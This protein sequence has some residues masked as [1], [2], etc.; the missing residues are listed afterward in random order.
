[1]Y[2][3]K[4]ILKL[5]HLHLKKIPYLSSLC[6]YQE[7]TTKEKTK[8]LVKMCTVN[9]MEIFILKL[10]LKKKKHNYFFSEPSRYKISHNIFLGPMLE[11]EA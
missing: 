6:L 2:K 7:I 5:Q 3:E 4:L 11:T 10:N 8:F 9:L 1:M